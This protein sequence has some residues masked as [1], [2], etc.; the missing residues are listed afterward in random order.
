[1]LDGVEAPLRVIE[2][3]RS[4][5][6]VAELHGVHQRG[7]QL[8]RFVGGE[9]GGPRVDVRRAVHKRTAMLGDPSCESLPVAQVET[10]DHGRASA[11]RKRAPNGVPVI[12]GEKQSAARE[13][14]QGLQHAA[15][16]G[17]RVGE[18]ETGAHR[19]GDIVETVELPD[20]VEGA[21]PGLLTGAPNS[22]KGGPTSTAGGVLFIGGASDRRF[23]AYETKTGRELWSVE[24]E[25]LISGANPITYMGKDG[26]QYVVVAAGTTL[27]AYTLP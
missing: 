5:E 18:P 23:R 13:G 11:G 6:P 3:Q 7:R 26:K 20:T 25:Q 24:S 10:L 9:T 16:L 2:C 12:V 15:H 27:L 22:Q 14:H 8:K 17:H 21:P 19:S 4:D 1:M